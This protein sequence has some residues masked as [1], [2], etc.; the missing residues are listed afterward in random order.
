MSK[1]L[2]GPTNIYLWQMKQ[3][4]AREWSQEKLESNEIL[5]RFF[6]SQ[7]SNPLMSL[8][9]FFLQWETFPQSMTYHLRLIIE[10]DSKKNCI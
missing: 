3:L 4:E 10:N 7:W 5:I 9:S 2:C 1:S 8:L 6:W